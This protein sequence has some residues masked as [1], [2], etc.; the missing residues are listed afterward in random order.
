MADVE[1]KQDIFKS[2][3]KACAT[4]ANL[5]VGFDALGLALEAPYDVVHL[6]RRSDA[7]VRITQIQG[8]DAARLPKDPSDNV[9][10]AVLIK[11]IDDYQLPYG[12]DISIEKGIALGSGMGGS[13]ASAVAALVA[14][15]HLL[16]EPLSEKVLFDYAC[17]GE[18]VASG[19]AHGD[20]VLPC[21]LGGLCIMDPLAQQWYRKIKVPAWSVTL[22]HPEIQLETKAARAALDQSYSMD[23]MAEYG[24]KFAGFLYALEHQD[25]GLI[26]A[27]ARKSFFDPSRAHFIPGFKDISCIAYEHGAMMCCISGSGPSVFALSE[28]PS[29]KMGQEMQKVFSDQGLGACVYSGAINQNGAAIIS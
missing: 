25:V 13:A 28:N 26:Q 7:K 5:A 27:V 24:A 10:S 23:Q 3:A 14:F 16:R 8:Q 2:S 12:V 22:V 17:Y 19:A 18:K 15:N 6:E 11:L 9:A 20:N 21:L 1:Y 29:P 4:S